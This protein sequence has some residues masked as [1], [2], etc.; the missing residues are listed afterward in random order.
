MTIKEFL[1]LNLDP[2][3]AESAICQTDKFILELPVNSLGSYYIPT[4]PGST[5]I[6]FLFIWE[7]T[8]E[9]FDFWYDVD[10]SLSQVY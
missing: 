9:G 7:N 4:K 10:K 2:N 3:V 1:K 8:K 5:I 6:S